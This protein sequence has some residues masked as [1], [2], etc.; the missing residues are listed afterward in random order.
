MPSNFHPPVCLPQL[1]AERILRLQQLAG[2]EEPQPGP[3][4]KL[5]WAIM[6]SPF[7]HEDTL[8]HFKSNKFF[9]LD[10]DQVFFFQQGALPCLT[11]EGGT[12]ACLLS[13]PHGH[14]QRH[15]VCACLSLTAQTCP[16]SPTLAPRLMV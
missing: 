8:S 10:E 14:Q 3:G 13:A 7:T 11:E 5:H 9:G 12:S 15:T 4:H 2:E 1:Q 6:T 16:C